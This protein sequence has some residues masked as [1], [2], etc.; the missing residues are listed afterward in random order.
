MVKLRLTRGGSKKRP[1]YRIVAMDS[2]VA[3]DGR[4][5]ERI[6]TYDPLQEPSVVTFK[7]DALQKW[8]DVGAKPT[9][10][11]A[12]LIRQYKRTAQQ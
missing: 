11:V 8:L 10:T 5:L 9:P 7:G 4:F 12:R 2:R 1:Y 6:G 3:R